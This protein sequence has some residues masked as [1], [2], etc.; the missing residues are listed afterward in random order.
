MTSMAMSMKG[1]TLFREY[2]ELSAGSMTTTVRFTGRSYPAF[3]DEVFD[4]DDGGD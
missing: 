4:A 1:S 2:W 3:T